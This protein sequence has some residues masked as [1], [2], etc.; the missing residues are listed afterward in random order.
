MTV[1][2]DS[3]QDPRPTPGPS[4]GMR[5]LEADFEVMASP[6]L[7]WMRV[8]VSPILGVTFA[9]IGLS[10][11]LGGV[12]GLIDQAKAVGLGSVLGALAIG[13]AALAISAVVFRAGWTTFR[14]YRKRG[15]L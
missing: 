2:P 5:M 1:P 10:F 4:R 14:A 15:L 11:F 3:H 13:V 7:L 12:M 8:L 9:E 6:P